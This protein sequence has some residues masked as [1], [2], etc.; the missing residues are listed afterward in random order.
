MGFWKKL[1][2]IGSFAAPIVAAPFT[3][4]ASLA[5]I[6]A[7][8]GAVPGLLDKNLKSAV[9][10]AGLG[11]IPGLGKMKAA[12]GASVAGKTAAKSGLSAISPGAAGDLGFSTKQLVEGGIDKVIKDSTTGAVLG[13]TGGVLGFLGKL[14]SAGLDPTALGLGALSLLGDDEEGPQRRESF[15]GTGPLTDPVSSLAMSQDLALKLGQALSRGGGPQLRQIPGLAPPPTD[16]MSPLLSSLF[17]QYLG[18]GPSSAPAPSE[19]PLVNPGGAMTTAAKK[20]VQR[21]KV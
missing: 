6:G 8:A 12:K 16:Q 11:A 7:G 19:E 4:G 3:G 13:K 14:K 2:K 18:G 1:A 20:A 10:G 21:R 15:K 17:D 5:L 9:L